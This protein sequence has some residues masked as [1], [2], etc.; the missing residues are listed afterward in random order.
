MDKADKI[1]VEMYLGTFLVSRLETY[2]TG[3]DLQ[4]TSRW[5]LAQNKIRTIS[6]LLS[7]DEEVEDQSK[8]PWKTTLI[9][10]PLTYY[11]SMF[12]LAVYLE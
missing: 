9:D 11:C 10:L 2:K 6:R 5:F 8:D 12:I 1:L 3:K 4:D 7:C